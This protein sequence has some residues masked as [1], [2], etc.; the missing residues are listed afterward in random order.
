[1]SCWEILGLPEDADK[2]SV[3]RQYAS[4][5]KRHR[6]DEDPEGF[7]R[8]R[9]AYEQALEWSEW[10]QQEEVLVEPPSAPI[11]LPL[12][13]LLSQPQESQGPSP[14]QRLAEQCLEA[15][16]ATNLAD[17][18]AQ[19]RLYGCA[20]E[21]EHG[22]LQHCLID[23]D[24]YA[25]A[26][27]AI[28]HLHWLTP[29]QHEGLSRAALEQLRG[30]LMEWAETRLNAAC[31]DTGRFIELARELAASPWLQGLDARQWLNQSLAIALLQAPGWSEP[32]FDAICAQQGWKQYGHH[33]PCP[34][35]WW[36][37][38]L[39]R[40]HCHTFLQ[41]QGRLTQLF[42]SSE[43]QAARMLFGVADEDARI[44]LSLTFSD[45]DWQA[46]EALYRTVE[47]RYSQLLY[48]M[49]QL[50][51]D[52]WRPLRRRPPVLAVPLAILSTSACMS[53]FLEY[54]LGGSFYASV[55]DMLLRTLSLGIIAWGLHTVCKPLSRIAWRLDRKLHAHFGRWL[56]LR[57][58]TPLPIRESLW[59]GLL[60]G[61][62]YLAGG[63]LGAAA[64]F[65]SLTVLAA[66]SGKA[67]SECCASFLS[68]VY[69]RVPAGI[70]IGFLLGVLVPLLLLGNVLA[71]NAPLAA[72]EGLQAWP[73]RTCAARQHTASPCPS[74]L[75]ADQ[76]HAPN[77]AK[78]GQP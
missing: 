58:P 74:Q 39:A 55:V 10:R 52:N 11:D 13:Q 4:L 29:W 59:V 73:Q 61:V 51:P 76:W 12:A 45:A 71:G 3:K 5:L 42:D 20:R 31:A 8:L 36:S 43:S 64:Y 41:Q 48:Q 37:Q 49:P 53:W 66:L 32:L 9:E 70:L 26:E 24:N 18:L 46:C 28:G 75:S 78:A 16:T 60:G 63:I 17:R 27:A 30:K 56:S 14:A 54:R 25:L 15:I 62:I 35:P 1:M 67:F 77:A 23:E 34:E 33:S 47:L 69:E 72:N 6:P 7:Q 40:S 50:A 22:L 44:R 57:R 38:L 65:S 21:F 19:A 2:R 68:R